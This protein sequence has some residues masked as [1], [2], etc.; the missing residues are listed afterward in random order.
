MSPC[1][2]PQLAN[3]CSSNSSNGAEDG[4][5]EGGVGWC[6]DLWLSTLKSPPADSL[7]THAPAAPE[8]CRCVSFQ[9]TMWGVFQVRVNFTH[10]PLLCFHLS[11]A[12]RHMT[13]FTYGPALALLAHTRRT[14]TC[15]TS[16]AHGVDRQL[17]SSWNS[18]DI[19]QAWTDH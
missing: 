19:E 14:L 11:L 1:F 5:W 13:L 3:V 8:P 9:R 12:Y 4:G 6:S 2:S 18:W 10:L 17:N 7:A 16:C 15:Y